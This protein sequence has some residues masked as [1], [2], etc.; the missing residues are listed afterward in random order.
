MAVLFPFRNTCSNALRFSRLLITTID[1]KC[2]IHVDKVDETFQ[3]YQKMLDDLSVIVDHPS[4]VG[5]WL[6]Q[7]KNARNYRLSH[8]SS[9]PTTC[10]YQFLGDTDRVE[11]IQFFVMPSLGICYRIKS[12]WGHC[13]MAACFLHLTST[14]LFVYREKVFIGKFDG[15]R[16]FAWGKGGS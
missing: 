5:D 9:V 2:T 16:I 12:Y 10:C 1:F 6:E 15:V 14:P 8:K 13:F 11:I 3:A 7:A 4:I